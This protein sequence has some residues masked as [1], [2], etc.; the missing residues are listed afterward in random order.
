MFKNI[1]FV[2]TL[3]LAMPLS[4]FATVPITALGTL[5][6]EAK[7]GNLKLSDILSSCKEIAQSTSSQFVNPSIAGKI[8]NI[9]GKT[10]EIRYFSFED[11][12]GVMSLNT[13]FS[14]YIEKNNLL[15]MQSLVTMP[16]LG[17]LFESFDFRRANKEDGVYFSMALRII[18]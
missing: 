2:I 14:S 9:N 3:L 11:T 7:E 15:D 16:L 17:I 4:A 8:L 1:S 5:K 10:Y 6:V 13:N 18:E 12:R